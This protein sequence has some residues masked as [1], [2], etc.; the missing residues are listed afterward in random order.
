MKKITINSIRS[1]LVILLVSQVIN[2]GVFKGLE[3]GSQK[4]GTYIYSITAQ[5][6]LDNSPITHKGLATGLT[7]N[8]LKK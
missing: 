1:F 8:V 4:L 5:P 2:L 6:F 3:L 7:I